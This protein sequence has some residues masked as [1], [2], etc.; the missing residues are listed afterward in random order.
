MGTFAHGRAQP[1][2][3]PN[4]RRCLVTGACKSRDELIRFVVAPD[5]TLAVDLGARLPGR[6][7]WLSADKQSLETACHKKAFSRAARVKVVVPHDIG[8]E[9]ERL[10]ARRCLDLIG[11]ARRAGAVVSGYEKTRAWL[12]NHEAGVL[13][14]AAD[15]AA[16][17][18]ARLRGLTWGTFCVD[19]L[20][21][22]ELGHVFGCVRA[23]H[24]AM[25]RGPLASRL[26]REA[27]RLSGFR[28]VEPVSRGVRAICTEDVATECR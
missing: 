23:V 4:T 2:D 5:G 8:A 25:E 26:I 18:K 1:V 17:E 14:A 13:L 10:L 12:T 15:S 20:T 9:V 7:L 22:A 19:N 6:G 27:R 24:G 21:A 11:L 16:P 28:T 3:T